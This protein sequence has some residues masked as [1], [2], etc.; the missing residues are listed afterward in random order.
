M[1]SYLW[2][3]IFHQSH[4]QSHTYIPQNTP[5]CPICSIDISIKCKKKKPHKPLKIR[6]CGAFLLTVC[7]RIRTP[8]PLVRSHSIN[9]VFTP[10]VEAGPTS[11][12]TL[13]LSQRWHYTILD[14]FRQ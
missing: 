8:D 5:K 12:P 7:E 3:S 13:S 2:D 6:I 9:A 4:T 10:F 11:S 1:L 14:D